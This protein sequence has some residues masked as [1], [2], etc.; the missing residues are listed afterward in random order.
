[1]SWGTMIYFANIGGAIY[2]GCWT[3]VAVPGLCIALFGLG[4]HLLTS[5]INVVANLRLRRW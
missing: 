1:M 3:W 5:A 2:H 4:M